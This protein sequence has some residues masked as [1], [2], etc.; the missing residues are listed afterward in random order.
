M[1]APPQA[2][3][4]SPAWGPAA[5]APDLVRRAAATLRPQLWHEAKDLI[6]RQKQS[7]SMEPHAQSM[8]AHG[9]PV[10]LVGGVTSSERTLT[11]LRDWLHRLNCRCL[12]APVRYG[13]GC[14]AQTAQFVEQALRQLTD[15]TGQRAVVV[16]HSRGG[17]FARAV[18]VRRPE[19]HRGLITL[20]SPLRRLIAVHPLMLTQVVALGLAGSL[21]VP[22]LMKVECLWGECCARFRADL[23]RPFP[24][25]VPF[26][27]VHSPH[28]HVVDWRST[29]DP[30][31][32]HRSVSTTHSGLLWYPESLS[33]IAQEIRTLLRGEPA[34]SPISSPAAHHSRP[35]G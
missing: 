16:A 20:G 11:P 12:V 7:Q 28:D 1:S 9:L 19:L 18:A 30:A 6:R 4:S 22:G 29:I 14:G 25:K 35:R 2:V 15:A 8:D 21:G 10:L 13:I 27:S 31:A 26:L 17:Q 32:R 34:P 33:V 3:P 5:L 23:L 24:S